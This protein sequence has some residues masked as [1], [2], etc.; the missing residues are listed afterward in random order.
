M[1]MTGR[2]NFST[3]LAFFKQKLA[4]YIDSPSRLIYVLL[5]DNKKTRYR[6]S[7]LGGNRQQTHQRWAALG[8]KR[9]EKD[10]EKIPRGKGQGPARLGRLCGW[11][12]P[13]V[14]RFP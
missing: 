7:L 11:T 2:S 9:K 8:G 10:K 14:G 12:L 13:N 3:M 6:Q 1:T 5:V 4:G